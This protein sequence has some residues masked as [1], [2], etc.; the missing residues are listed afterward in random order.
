MALTILLVCAAILIVLSA[1]SLALHRGALGRIVVYGGSLLVSLAGLAAALIHL[2]GQAPD[3]ALT[4][5]IGLPWLGAHFLLDPALGILSG[6]GQSG[7][8]PPRASTRSA[9]AGMRRRRSACC[10][11]IRCSSPP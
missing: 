11:S 8:A 4:L 6:R 2:L 1:L 9:M 10:R 7:R 3:Q 5:P